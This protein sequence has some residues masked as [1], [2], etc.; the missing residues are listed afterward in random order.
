MTAAQKAKKIISV[1]IRENLEADRFSEIGVH[2]QTRLDVYLLDHRM[3]GGV[4]LNRPK[5]DGLD[6]LSLDDG[7]RSIHGVV[8]N[9][10]NS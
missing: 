8:Q 1:I 2:H 7:L 4:R 6:L 5:L 9:L 3:Y 10:P